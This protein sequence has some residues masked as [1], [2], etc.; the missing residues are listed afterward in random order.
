MRL[1]PSPPSPVIPFNTN[2]ANRQR[3]LTTESESFFRIQLSLPEAVLDPIA[4]SKAECSDSPA[5][6]LAR[7][8]M[9]QDLG[10]H[11]FKDPRL[12]EIMGRVPRHCFVPEAL[13]DQAYADGPLAIGSGQTIS[14]PFIVAVMSEGLKLS[15]GEKVLEIGTGSGYQ[16]AILAELGGEIYSIERVAPLLREAEARLAGLGYDKIHFREGDGTAGW[17][18]AAPFDAILAAAGAPGIAAPWKA[19]LAEGG[20]LVVPVGSRRSQTLMLYTK[21]GNKLEEQIICSCVFVPLLG[22]HGWREEESI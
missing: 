12:L 8:Q 10:T 9:I 1:K 18:E 14:Q 5:L 13:Q 2:I 15:A 17:P 3:R 21:R 7:R 11:G 16:T 6:I 19:Q 22:E 20:R 4:S